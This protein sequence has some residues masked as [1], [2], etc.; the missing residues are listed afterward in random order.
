[1]TVKSQ[2]PILQLSFEIMTFGFESQRLLKQ[3]VDSVEPS[4]ADGIL[5]INMEFRPEAHMH[6]AIASQAQPVAIAAK[7]VGHWCYQSDAKPHRLDL[8]IACRACCAV[9]YGNDIV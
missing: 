2:I 3:S 4:C 9:R 6:L 7:I 8:K 5:E 1:M